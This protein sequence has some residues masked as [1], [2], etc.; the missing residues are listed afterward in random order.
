MSRRWREGRDEEVVEEGR[1]T[2]SSPKDDDGETD[3]RDVPRDD[4]LILYGGLCVAMETV[5]VCVHW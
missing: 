3:K 5:C 4:T 1:D 2:L